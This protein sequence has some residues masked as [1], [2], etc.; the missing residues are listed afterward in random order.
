MT[1]GQYGSVGAVV[2]TVPIQVRGVSGTLLVVRP[3]RRVGELGDSPNE[4][5]LVNS[6]Q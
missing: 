1:H 4:L 2:A 5:P 6:P 3:H